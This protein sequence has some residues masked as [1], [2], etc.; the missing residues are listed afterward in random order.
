MRHSDMRLSA[1]TY[2]D[3]TRLP[4]YQEL[5]KLT[6]PLPSSTASPNSDFSCPKEGN[7]V[8]SGKSAA[9]EKVTVLR[10]ETVE[11]ST[12][13]PDRPNDEMAEREGFEP[14]CRFEAKSRAYV[15]F[16]EC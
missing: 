10:G 11:L 8:Q 6:S 14:F 7:A 12:P 3:T 9:I 1:K 4:M 15:D 2:T 13:S 5:A 16:V